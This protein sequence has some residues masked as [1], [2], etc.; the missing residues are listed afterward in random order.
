MVIY[1]IRLTEEV[2]GLLKSK[3]PDPCAWIANQILAIAL[4][5]TKQAAIAAAKI[6]PNDIFVAAATPKDI[7]CLEGIDDALVVK[8]PASTPEKSAKKK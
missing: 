8:S 2:D 5:A 6:N 3:I 7:E 1:L 4:E